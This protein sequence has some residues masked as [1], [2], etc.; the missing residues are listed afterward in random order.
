MKTYGIIYFQYVEKSGFT[1]YNIAFF[2]KYLKK[3]LFG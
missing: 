1:Y 3:D 2:F